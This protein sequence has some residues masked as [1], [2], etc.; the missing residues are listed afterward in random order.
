MA[1]TNAEI[2]AMFKPVRC[3]RCGNGVYDI[4]TVEVTGRYADCSVWRTP[5]CKAVVD[6]RGETG[7]T[8]RKDYEVIDKSRICPDD[9]TPF[10]ARMRMD[11]MVWGG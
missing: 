11:G 7:W 3:N 6:G 1:H 4:G 8:T 10:R 5:C 2:A 9:P